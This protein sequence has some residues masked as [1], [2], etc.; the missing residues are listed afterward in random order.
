MHQEEL[1]IKILKSGEIRVKVKGVKGKKCV[2]G[3]KLIQQSLGNPEVKEHQFTSEYY[4]PEPN[5]RI[6][7]T[8][9]QGQGNF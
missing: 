7:P 1:E 2:E 3:I 6:S 4:E 5:A 8:Q 9:Q